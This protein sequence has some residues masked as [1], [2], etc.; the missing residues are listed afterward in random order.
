MLADS[1]HHKVEQGMKKK[2]QVADFQDFV[3]LVNT[4]RKSFAMYYKSFVLVPHGVSKGKYASKKPKLK[5]VQV[6]IFKRGSHK[7]FWET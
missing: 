6:V 1:F 5:N 7:I 4:C 3:D 2:K